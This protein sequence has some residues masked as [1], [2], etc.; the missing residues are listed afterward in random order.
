MAD[1]GHRVL[2]ES[3]LRIDTVSKRP[4]KYGTKTVSNALSAAP[5]A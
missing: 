1:F 2:Q 5:I 3:R 4:S